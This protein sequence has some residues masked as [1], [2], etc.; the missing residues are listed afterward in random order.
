MTSKPGQPQLKTTIDRQHL[1]NLI[2]GAC[3]V[4]QSFGRK[5]EELPFMVAIYEKI[6]NGY[7]MDEIENAFLHHMKISPTIPTPYDILSILNRR[8]KKG[9]I[10]V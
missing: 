10:V 2:A 6:L 8:T 9:Q 1:S 3:L 4:Q 5:P 7:Q